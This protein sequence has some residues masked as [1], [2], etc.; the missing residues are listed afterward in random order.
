[1]KKSALTLAMV[2]MLSMPAVARAQGFGIGARAGTLGLGAEAAMGLSNRVVLRGGLGLLPFKPSTTIN[3]IDFT[4]TLPK[5]WYNVGLDF[6][7]TGAMRIG[8]GILFKSDNPVVD[9]TIPSNK[10]VEIGDQ[11]YTSAE[12]S[13]LHGVLL[14]KKKAPYVLLGFGKHTASGVGLFLDLGVA[15]TGDPTVSLSAQ[16]NQTLVDSPEFQSELRKEET[17]I[18]NDAGTYLRYWPILDLGLRIGLGN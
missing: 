1:M 15:F 10:S 6:Y 13:S 18:R 14:S 3:D 4:L 5:T 7:L 8:A 17:K 11:S 16:G 2:C 9:G 12:I